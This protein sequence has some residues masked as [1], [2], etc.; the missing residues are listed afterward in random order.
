MQPVPGQAGNREGEFFVPDLCAPRPVLMMILLSQLMVIL[1]TLASSN[2]PQFNWDLLATNSL[3]VQW[4]VLLSA[5]LLCRLRGPLSRLSLLLASIGA[6][7]YAQ[8][9]PRSHAPDFP[10]NEYGNQSLHN[11][12]LMAFLSCVNGINLMSRCN[13]RTIKF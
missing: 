3:F 13:D 4:V 9:D 12:K 5:A 1:Y 11:H 8:P 7:Q 2:L 6:A 10:K